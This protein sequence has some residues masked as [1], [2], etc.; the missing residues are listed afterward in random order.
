MKTKT[1]LIAIL[2]VAM[3]LTFCIPAFAA[4]SDVANIT[5]KPVAPGTTV[6]AYQ[7]IKIEKIENAVGID[8]GD[9]YKYTFVDGYKNIIIEALGL[10]ATPAPT[11]TAILLALAN[12]S[13]DQVKDIAQKLKA[14]VSTVDPSFTDTA[15]NNAYEI[16]FTDIA[17]GWYLLLDT[18]DYSTQTNIS[19][20]ENFPIL[21][22]VKDTLEISLKTN[23]YPVPEKIA[24]EKTVSVGDTVNYEVTVKI[25]VFNI[26]W[27]KDTIKYVLHDKMADG[28]KYNNDVKVTI[29]NGDELTGLTVAADDKEFTIAFGKDGN[30]IDNIYKNQAKELVLEYTATVTT[31]APAG[32]SDLVNDFSVKVNDNTQG[33]KATVNIYGI[34]VHKTNEDKEILPGVKFEL[35]DAKDNL[36]KFVLSDNGTYVYDPSATTTSLTTDDKGNITL[37][38]LKEGTYFLKETDTL[39]GYNKLTGKIELTIAGKDNDMKTVDDADGEDAYFDITVVNYTGIHVPETGGIGTIAFTLIGLAM[40]AGVGVHLTISRKRKSSIA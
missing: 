4:Q 1:T 22:E 2:T 8:T 32:T 18:T 20:K 38:G 25:P 24:K 17:L 34:K 27:A 28:L 3:M 9:F 16:N 7:I 12:A 39:D 5:I 13:G 10:V 15:A 21:A 36:M 11:D 23:T 30:D 33:D 29:K 6:D 40:I 14:S 19:A 35:Y 37:W 26:E 31:N